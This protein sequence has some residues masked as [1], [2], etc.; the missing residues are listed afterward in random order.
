VTE[1]GARPRLQKCLLTSLLDRCAGCRPAATPSSCWAPSRTA[2]ACTSSWRSAA[3]A[4]SRRCWRCGHHAAD[5]LDSLVS[6]VSAARR[7]TMAQIQLMSSAGPAVEAH[8]V[9]TASLV[10]GLATQAAHSTARAVGHFS[11]VSS[12][13]PHGLWRRT[14]GRCRRRTW[15]ASCTRRC[16]RWRRATSTACTT[17]T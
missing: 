8:L 5:L 15:H 12:E 17:A 3:A 11:G 6:S 16:R 2:R 13:A 1:V 14:T 4:T 10:S 7:V 9:D